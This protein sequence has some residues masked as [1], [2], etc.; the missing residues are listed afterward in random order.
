VIYLLPVGCFPARVR[1]V[2]FGWCTACA[3]VGGV[4]APPAA[5]LLPPR[6]AL[7]AFGALMLASAAAASISLLEAEAPRALPAPPAEGGARQLRA[8][9][10]H[11]PPGAGAASG[12]W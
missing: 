6:V 9:S 5:G 1:G 12:G 4:L 8:S 7:G 3:R 10:R 2:G 11:R